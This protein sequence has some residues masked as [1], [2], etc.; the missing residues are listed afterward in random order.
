MKYHFLCTFIPLSFRRQN[1]AITLH[2][3]YQQIPHSYNMRQ[4]VSQG[5]IVI[6][7]YARR[8]GHTLRSKST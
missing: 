4:N 7:F 1:H 3:K 6:D 2:T 5:F 8:V